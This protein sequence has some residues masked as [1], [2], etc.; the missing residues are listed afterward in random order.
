VRIGFLSQPFDVVEPPVDGRY[1]I[2]VLTYNFA[3]ELARRGHEVTVYATAG[4]AGRSREA[5]RR[6]NHRIVYIYRPKR[7]SRLAM[8]VLRRLKGLSRHQLP[9]MMSAWFDPLYAI[10][11]ALDARV[12][13]LEVIHVQNFS[14]YAPFFK[15]IYPEVKVI[16]HMHCEW[17]NQIDCRTIRKRLRKVDRIL[18]TS[19]YIR[20]RAERAL[21]EF[22]GRMCTLYNGVDLQRFMPAGPPPPAGESPAVYFIGR[23]AP[24]KGVHILIE[25]FERVVEKIPHARL[26]LAGLPLLLS[27]DLLYAYDDPALRDAADR[28]YASGDGSLPTLGWQETLARLARDHVQFL[29]EVSHG[30]LIK[31]LRSAALVVQPSIIQES[32]GMPVAEAMAIGLPVIATSGGALPEI[33]EHEVTGLI[34]ERGN[35]ESLADAMIK[36]LRSPTKRRLMGAA[37]RRRALERFGFA[38][39]ARQLEGHYVAILEPDGAAPSA[40]G[41]GQPSKRAVP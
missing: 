14:Q 11:A 2:P 36:L 34:V 12:R 29:G 13:G 4:R 40:A 6:T 21:P 5:S 16:V 28:F 31:R 26:C 17:L 27:K 24:D 41:V 9:F 35:A 25:A 33:V 20:G 8:G 10:Q 39:L 32:F 15:A 18:C 23:I 38:D 3:R 7:P 22:A 30:E 37:G 19:D 1:S